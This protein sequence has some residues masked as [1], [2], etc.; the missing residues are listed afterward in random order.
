MPSILQVSDV[1][2]YDCA[3]S[4]V[5]FA[6]I[7]TLVNAGRAKPSIVAPRACERCAIGII[8]LAYLGEGATTIIQRS[9]QSQEAHTVH[10]VILAS[11]WAFILSR[12]S[13]AWSLDLGSSLVTL[14]FETP[15]LVFSALGRLDDTCSVLQIVFQASRILT[16]LFLTIYYFFY[17][18]KH[19]DVEC[20]AEESQPFLQTNGNT[21][22]PSYGTENTSRELEF[23]D[24]EFSQG[25]EDEDDVVDIKRERAKR[26]REKGGWW[27]YLSDFSIFLPFLIP[28]KDRKVQLSILTCLVCIVATRAF[29]VL[30]PRQL[31]IVADQL[32]ANENPFWA[33]SVWLMLY[34]LSHDV[35]IGAIQALA[36]I[37]IKQ[38]SYR[39]LTNAAFNHVLSLPMEFHSERDSAE[40][41]K[42]IEQGEALTNVLDNVLIELL[43]TVVDLVI[44]VIFLYWKFN[45]YI[46]L[47]MAMAAVIFITFEVKATS[48]NLDNR[49]ESSKSK[50][51]ETRV[52]HQAV[53]GWQTVTYFNMFG[54]EKQRFG[55]SVE[56]QLAAAKSWEIRD[57]FIQSMLEAIVPCAFFMIAGLI[58][59]DILQGRSS[60]GDFVFFI[61]YW[62]YLVWPLK[63]LSHQYRYLMSDLVDAE[64]L[65]FL[66]QTKPSITDKEGATDLIKVEGRVSFNHV[67]FSYDPRK[68]TIQDLSLSV[69][70]GQTVALVGETGAGKSSIMK[71]LLRFYD[72]NEGSITIDDHDIR[73]VTLSSLRNALGVVPQDPLLFNASILENMRYARP[74]AT[75]AEIHEACRSAAIHDKILSFVDGYD[76]EVGEQGVKL[77]GGEIQRL[78]IARVFLKNPPILI[79]DEATSAIDTNTESSIQAALDELKRERS[80]FIIAHRLSTIVGADKILVIHE[81]KVV[82][83][84]THIELMS[85]DGRYS[86]L[87]NKQVASA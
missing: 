28:K 47:A 24:E 37:S 86:A 74:S 73:D 9:T 4:A 8:L 55:H 67:G 23:D 82:E 81:G 59:L 3:I 25:S 14:A 17:R 78:A 40:V 18:G 31:G 42:A 72:I 16:L 48:W 57:A 22:C 64:R 52:M 54:F 61:Q 58:I 83:S 68:A 13:S 43:P 75:D 29:N 12:P 71:L 38:Y 77:S 21:D 84:G 51:E 69:E 6:S 27:G 10:L 63:F 56:K 45:S 66:L 36:K 85:K 60:P 5:A 1:L 80:T 46:A 35:F 79:L 87:W 62:E 50:R 30:I 7:A 49:R 2:H 70:P 39:S 53:Q 41:M 44:G 11:L 32:L 19:Y 65:L 15:L 26:L 76:T 34:L 20:D 33:L